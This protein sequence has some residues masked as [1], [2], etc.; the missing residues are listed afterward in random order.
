MTSRQI[1]STKNTFCADQRLYS[2]SFR[3]DAN[4][5]ATGCRN[6]DYFRKADWLKW[7]PGKARARLTLR[8]GRHREIT[9]SSSSR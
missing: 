6:P 2:P 9:Y 8:W 7:R 1:K 3:T 4:S 5:S